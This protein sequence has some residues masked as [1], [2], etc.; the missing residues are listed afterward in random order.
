M[1]QYLCCRVGREWFGIPV[2]YVIEVLH[3]VALNEIPGASPD[4]L[5][6]L[7]LRDTVMPVIDLRVRFGHVDAAIELDTPIIALNTP[8]GPAGIVVD[9]V[10]DVE[11]I[12]QIETRQDDALPHT[13]GVARLGER[14]LQIL[15]VDQLRR[16]VVVGE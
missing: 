15:N 8:Q 7:T 13:Q 6:L 4:V 14:L 11:Q 16:G 10:D 9:D 12:S 5:G 2:V 1:A 3:F